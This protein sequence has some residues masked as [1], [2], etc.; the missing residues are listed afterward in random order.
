MA[1]EYN[2]LVMNETDGAVSFVYTTISSSKMPTSS[3]EKAATTFV[4]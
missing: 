4:M 1:T 3:T 2:A